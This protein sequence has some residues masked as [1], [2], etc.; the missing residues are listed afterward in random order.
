M[1]HATPAQ[2]TAVA[3][4]VTHEVLEALL[5]DSIANQTAAITDFVSTPFANEGT[6]D[7]TA[8]FRVTLSWTLPSR[9]G[10]SHT[11][12]WILKRWMAGGDRD[13]GLGIAEPRE[14]LAWERGWLRPGKLPAGLVVP[15]VGAWRSPDNS[16]AWLALTDVSAELATYSRMSLPGELALERTQAIL[17]R[18]AHLHA[19]WERPENQAQLQ[20]SPW[21]RRPQEYL[22]DTAPTYARALKRAPKVVAPPAASRPAVWDSLAA[23]LGAFLEA[24][25]AH[26]RWLWEQLLIDRTTLVEGLAAY[27]QTLLHNDLDDRNIG[28]RWPGGRV[29][30]GAAAVD[31][32]EL[33]LIDWEWIALG[34]AAIDVANIVQRVPVLIAPGAPIP[35][36]VW[37]DGLAD[38]YF[39]H[40]RAAG[41][42]SADAAEWRRSYG[43][44][45]VA[46]GLAQM[47][48]LH[49]RLRR[50]IRGELPPPEIVGVP[51]QVVRQNLRAG[52]PM[53]EQMEDRVIREARRWLG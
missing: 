45:T 23:D 41:G 48:F 53:M 7:T 26:D 24:R 38:Y 6:N 9:P 31:L 15:I 12:T 21:L 33:V 28:L 29:A 52:L 35:Q 25:P 13:S 47:P 5:R 20:A 11:A 3:T 4:G 19:I 46:Q 50:A 42:R 18:M 14:A 27:P 22:W 39:A 51:E 1:M 49:G 2:P 44:A 8:L 30:A 32:P 37:T 36:A 34:P 16:V 10:P 43:L 40:Y 17:A